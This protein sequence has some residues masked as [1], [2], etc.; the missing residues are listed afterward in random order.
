[1]TLDFETT[2]ETV[3]EFAKQVENISPVD[4][5]ASLGPDENPVLAKGRELLQGR[6]CCE[7]CIVPAG[8][9]KTMQVVAGM[10]LPKDVY[11]RMPAG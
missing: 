7:A 6:G 4:V 1:V 8:A 3:K 9:V 2:C 10:A 11:L 5:I